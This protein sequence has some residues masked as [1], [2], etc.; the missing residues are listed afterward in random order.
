MMKNCPALPRKILKPSG[1]LR[2]AHFFAIFA[3]ALL[4]AVQTSAQ[5]TLAPQTAAVSAAVWQPQLHF[6]A[7][8][9]WIND[10]N[11]PIF[12]NGQYHL[13]F[14]LNPSGDQWVH[15]S[16][17]HAVSADLIHWKQLPLAIPEE[18]GVAIF[19][20]STVE[21]RDNTSGLCGDPGQKTPGC[22]IAIYTGASTDL[23][24]Q[25]LAFS[26]DGGS[27]WTKSWT[28]ELPRP[29]GLL[30]RP[31]PELGDGGLSSREAQSPLLPLEEP[32]RM[33]S[34]R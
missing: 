14:Q 1:G 28:H 26:R 13:F 15:M 31:E 3:L 21:D 4:L 24:N 16:W 30:A 9:N 10:P 22:L 33:G 27:S 18:D 2:P 12:L 5:Q 8:P 29:Q 7:S 32:P 34:R 20:G 6:H 23:Q 19:S 25:N 17:G 11:G